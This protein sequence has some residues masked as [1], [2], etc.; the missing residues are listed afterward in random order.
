MRTKSY[1]IVILLIFGLAK[2]FFSVQR[3]TF[4]KQLVANSA[5]KKYNL[6]KVLTVIS[7]KSKS[8]LCKTI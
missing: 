1:A 2:L 5:T 6:K 8:L 4:A 7:R 3:F